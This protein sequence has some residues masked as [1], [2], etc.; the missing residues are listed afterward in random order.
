MVSCYS[1]RDAASELR[2]P[3]HPFPPHRRLLRL[4][5]V[6]VAGCAEDGASLAFLGYTFRPDRDQYG[7]PQRYWIRFDEGEGS[8]GYWSVGLHSVLSS[9]H[10]WLIY[11]PRFRQAC[12]LS[13]PHGS[14]RLTRHEM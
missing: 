3:L 7:C 11:F 10:Y 5:A 14:I 6:P 4:E 8:G 13:Q 1:V 2:E 12:N 9:L